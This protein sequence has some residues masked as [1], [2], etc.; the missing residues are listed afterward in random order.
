MIE[1]LGLPF[2]TTEGVVVTGVEDVALRTRLRPGDLLRRINGEDDRHAR[3]LDRD[4]EG[5]RQRL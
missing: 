3:D 2:G 4:R 1:E 5:A